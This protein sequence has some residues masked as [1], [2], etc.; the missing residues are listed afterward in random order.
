MADPQLRDAN[1]W[2][3]DLD[4]TLYPVSANLFEQIDKRMCD[5]I[6]RY[7]DIDHGEAYKVQKSYFRQ[8]GTTLRGMMESHQMDPTPYLDFVHDVDLEVI[9]KDPQLDDALA[10]L[11]GRKFVFTNATSDYAARVLERIGIA[12]HFD[13][14]FAIEE[15]NYIPKPDP[16]AYD[17]A[18][19]RF[20]VD[21]A[22]SVMVEDVARNLIPAAALG[23]TTVWVQTGNQWAHNNSETVEPDHETDNLSA[24]LADVAGIH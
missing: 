15:A 21:P 10:R 19:G 18:V 6:A 3:F 13:D 8:F 16:S 7:L 23:M 14:L 17:H 4:N 2:I 11:P 5:F 22:K 9:K 12:R 20:G 1:Y 24:W